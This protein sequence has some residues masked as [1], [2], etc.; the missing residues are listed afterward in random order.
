MTERA[1]GLVPISGGA[2]AVY[3]GSNPI[4]MSGDMADMGLEGIAEDGETGATVMK[5]AGNAD[6]SS[7]G[8]FN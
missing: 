7:S 2:Y 3:V 1:N 4:F 5:L 6:V 8:M